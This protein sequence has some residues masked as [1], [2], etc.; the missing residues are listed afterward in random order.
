MVNR[1]FKDKRASLLVLIM[2]MT[3]YGF[4]CMTKYCFSSAM[5]FIVDE[6][7]MTKFETGTIA[8]SFWAV[9][10]V[11]QLFGGVPVNPLGLGVSHNSYVDLVLRFGYLGASAIILMIFY[12]TIKCLQKTYNERNYSLLLCKLL[13]MYWGLSLSIFDG[14]ISVFWYAL[15]LAF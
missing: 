1:Y 15:L 8:A 13:F 9:Y 3:S 2:I 4:L 10:A 5:V 12:S 6:G 14:P 7:Y 11:T